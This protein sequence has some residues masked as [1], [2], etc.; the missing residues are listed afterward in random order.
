MNGRARWLLLAVLAAALRLAAAATKP[1]LC[2]LSNGT[3]VLAE[4]DLP[5]SVQASERLQAQLEIQV[6]AQCGDIVSPFSRALCAA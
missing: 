4:H 2:N 5:I 1:H 3:R 6:S